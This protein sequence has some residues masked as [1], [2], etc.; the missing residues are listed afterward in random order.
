MWYIA[1]MFRRRNWAVGTVLA[2]AGWFLA[3]G[4]SVGLSCPSP[5]K[6]P[7]PEFWDWQEHNKRSSLQ[8]AQAQFG[9]PWPPQ[10]SIECRFDMAAASGATD[11]FKWLGVVPV[12]NGAPVMLTSPQSMQFL[13]ALQLHWRY[14]YG[15]PRVTVFDRQEVCLIF[16]ENHKFAVDWSRNPGRPAFPWC[17]AA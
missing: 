16:A 15:G 14:P 12:E 9:P 3:R 5:E 8:M 2:L 1:A 10:V 7:K 13:R 6:L 17:S 4:M 11:V